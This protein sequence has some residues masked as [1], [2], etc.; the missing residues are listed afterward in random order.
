MIMGLIL[1]SL[2]PLF[3]FYKWLQVK[4]NPRQSLQRFFG[5]MAIM[6]LLV[7]I[8]TFLLVFGIRLIFPGA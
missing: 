2:L 4:I 1:F 3:L 7:F 6:F 5:F 8:Y